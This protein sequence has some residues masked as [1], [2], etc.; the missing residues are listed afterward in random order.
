MEGLT[1]PGT[2][3]LNGTLDRLPDRQNQEVLTELETRKIWANNYHRAAEKDALSMLD[4]AM[5]SGDQ[6][7]PIRE[8]IEEKRGDGRWGKWVEKNFE[9]TLKTAQV[10]MRLARH[11]KEIEAQRS[12]PQSPLSIDAAMKMLAAPKDDD[13]PKEE[14]QQP[15]I[16][17][18]EVEEDQAEEPTPID[19]EAL[20]SRIQALEEQARKAAEKAKKAEDAKKRAQDKADKEAKKVAESKQAEY[21]ELL[22]KE[23]QEIHQHL[24]RQLADVYA[25]YGIEQSPDI[26]EV[27]EEHFRAAVEDVRSQREEDALKVLM[28]VVRLFRKLQGYEPEEAARAFLNRPSSPERS[29]EVIVETTDWL[30][31]CVREMESL[32][33]KGVLRAVKGE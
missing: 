24:E 18:N 15:T 5:N 4:N 1:L 17:Q 11:R 33:T 16:D 32:T 28:D 13:E 3:D 29:K 8:S 9:G 2:E 6:L 31:R 25:R 20:Q 12:A 22:S 26:F 10:Y 14:S 30:N 27:D 23:R 19:T 7:I 21:L